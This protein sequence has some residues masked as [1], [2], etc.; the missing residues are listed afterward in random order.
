MKAI[1]VIALVFGFKAGSHRAYMIEFSVQMQDLV[2]RT[3]L[4][5]RL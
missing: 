5:R 4:R 1:V 3:E 2:S